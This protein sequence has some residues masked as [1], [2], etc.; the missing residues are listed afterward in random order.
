[1]SLERLRKKE[2][3][4]QP[5]G[6]QNRYRKAGAPETN[7]YFLLALSPKIKVSQHSYKQNNLSNLSRFRL[8]SRVLLFVYVPWV[9]V[10]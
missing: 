5:V 4:L 10:G 7:P 6:D 1:M 9:I 2:L 8:F 3:A